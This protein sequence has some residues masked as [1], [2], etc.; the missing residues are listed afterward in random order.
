VIVM[1]EDNSWTRRWGLPNYVTTFHWEF[2]EDGDALHHSGY[3][4]GKC[5]QCGEEYLVALISRGRCFTCG[6]RECFDREGL[7]E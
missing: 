6:R 3:T 7:S 1:L 5:K 2:N 4:V